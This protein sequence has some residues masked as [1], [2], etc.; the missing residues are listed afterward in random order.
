MIQIQYASLDSF[1]LLVPFEWYEI[2]I[3]IPSTKKDGDVDLNSDNNSIINHCWSQIKSFFFCMQRDENKE[4]K[5]QKL[6]NAHQK[7]C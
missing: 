2:D 3:K 5:I 6:D 4:N 1:S 7:K